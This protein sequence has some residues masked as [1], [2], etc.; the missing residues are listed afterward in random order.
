[1]GRGG[2]EPTTVR[3]PGSELRRLTQEG[4]R[5]RAKTINGIKKRKEKEVPTNYFAY[6]PTNYFDYVRTDFFVYSE[7]HTYGL[8]VYVRTYEPLRTRTRPCA[9]LQAGKLDAKAKTR[10]N[11]KTRP[12]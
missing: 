5:R 9:P 3:D 6:A 2:E 7:V 8:L 12:A 1:M 10:P 4:E 11:S